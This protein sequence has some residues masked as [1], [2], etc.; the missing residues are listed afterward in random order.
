MSS[1]AKTTQRYSQGLTA[2]RY[3][4]AAAGCVFFA[5]VYYQ[6][7]HGVH[8]PFMT[9]MF[10]VPLLGGAIPALIAHFANVRPAPR[11]SRQ[12]W[13][14][15]LT[16]LTIAC[17]LRGIFEIAGTNSPLLVVYPAV[18]AVFAIVAAICFVRGKA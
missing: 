9:L 16:S 14:L 5:F 8:S 4:V 15:A 18:A 6:F 7:S 3:G 12:A 13:A 1:S 2:L 17:C 11:A 10:L